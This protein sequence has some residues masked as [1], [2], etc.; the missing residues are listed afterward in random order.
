MKINLFCFSS[1]FRERGSSRG[2]REDCNA[3]RHTLINKHTLEPTLYAYLGS[4]VKK[5]YIQLM[6]KKN[7]FPKHLL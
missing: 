4:I 2:L 1:Y 6:A 5:S 7:I 3:F